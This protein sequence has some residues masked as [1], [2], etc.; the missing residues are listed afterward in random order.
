MEKR[1]NK[2]MKLGRSVLMRFLNLVV[3]VLIVA[4]LGVFVVANGIMV[5]NLVNQWQTGMYVNVTFGVQAVLVF[6]GM[7]GS[8]AAIKEYARVR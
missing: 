2:L 4:V 3:V 7:V 8:V 5:T 1:M 6:L